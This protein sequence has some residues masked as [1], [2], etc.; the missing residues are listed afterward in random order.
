MHDMQIPC[1][2]SLAGVKGLVVMVWAI[3][4]KSKYGT[5]SC[6]V[7][8]NGRWASAM[9]S[10]GIVTKIFGKFETTWSLRCVSSRQRNIAASACPSLVYSSRHNAAVHR[11]TEYPTR[12]VTTRPI[13]SHRLFKRPV[14]KIVGAPDHTSYPAAW[15]SRPTSTRASA[16]SA[17]LGKPV[18][19]QVF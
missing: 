16:S 9:S 5:T 15:S 11:S 8:P 19:S 12:I 17:R 2:T 18:D 13:C 14:T 10:C 1:L 7:S 4:I 6:F 3:V